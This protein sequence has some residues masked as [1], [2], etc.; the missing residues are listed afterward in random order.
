MNATQT[1]QVT[2]E[3]L[4]ALSQCSV[5]GT[6]AGLTIE[7]PRLQPDQYRAVN[8]VLDSL[9]GKWTRAREQHVFADKTTAQVR[10]MLDVVITSG[11][12][13]RS[14]TQDQLLGFFETPAPLAKRLVELAGIRAR[15]TVLEPSAG[16]GAICHAIINFDVCN[17]A[18]GCSIFAIEVDEKRARDLAE[19][20]PLAIVRNADFLATDVTLTQV[21]R[22]VAN[23]PFGGGREVAHIIRMHQCLKPGGRMVSVMPSSITFRKD[24]LYAEFREW[25]QRE[26]AE[27]IPLPPG[28]FKSS[29]TMVATVIVVIDKPR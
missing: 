25:L 4:A 10:A 21:D 14:P 8:V 18:A 6:P 7:G 24:G 22:I 11:E 23:P 13:S 17:L 28:S 26:R 9:G 16:T 27:I 12:Y 19:E 3:V 2:P 29:G 5:S 1:R 15:D 20:I